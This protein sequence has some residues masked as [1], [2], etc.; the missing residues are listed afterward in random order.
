MFNILLINPWIYDFAAYDLWAKPL[1]LLY[2]ASILKN[3][4]YQINF[5]DCLNRYHPALPK[6]TKTK[7]YGQGKYYAQEIEKPPIYKNIPRKY[8]RYGIP[9]QIFKSELKSISKPSVILVTSMM[10]YWYLG[11]FDVIK[12]LKNYFKDVPIILGGIYAT[13]CYEHAVKYSK[14]DYVIKGKDSLQVL[15]LV[16]NLTKNTHNYSNFFQD[17][18]SYPY[19][20]Y[21]LIKN[22]N[23]VCLLTSQGCPYRCTYCATHLL[24]PKFIQR[25]PIKVVDEIEYYYKKF[26]VKNFVFYDDALLIN[27]EKHIYIIL[28]EVAKRGIKC[29]FHTPNGMNINPINRELARLL[30]KLNF[31]TIRLSFETSC[32]QLQK[33]TGNK[34]TN[35]A[36]EEAVKNLTLAGYKAKD[37]EVYVMTGLPGQTYKEVVESIKFVSKTGA[38]VKLVEFSLIPGTEEYNRAIEEFGFEPYSDPLLHNNSILLFQSRSSYHKL[39]DLVRKLNR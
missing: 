25:N 32:A 6:P 33:R 26:K 12:I 8:K 21:D 35:Q 1:G 22:L 39:K 14:A 11:V 10:T 2:I 19:P 20:A 23:Y 30:F 28:E 5:I 37:I 27:P 29:Y 4:G 17:L 9:I 7:E 34:V 16:D 18:D 15:K 3:Y 13:L 24:A 31:K 38:K 36:L